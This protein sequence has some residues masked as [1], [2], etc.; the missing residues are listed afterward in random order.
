MSSHHAQQRAQEIQQQ[1]RHQPMS[2]D[3]SFMQQLQ[4]AQQLQQQQQ[5]SAAAR[6]PPPPSIKPAAGAVGL[7]DVLAAMQSGASAGPAALAGSR[8]LYRSPVLYGSPVTHHVLA[9]KVGWGLV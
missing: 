4:H 6:P 5:G 1:Q 9:L 8:G 7:S 2:L 3:L